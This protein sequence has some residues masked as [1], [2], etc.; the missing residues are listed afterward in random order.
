MLSSPVQ[1][2]LSGGANKS[3]GNSLVCREGV[4][5]SNHV[6]VR[7][8]RDNVPGTCVVCCVVLSKACSGGMAAN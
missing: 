7:V 6:R 8:I 4:P 2:S 1:C 5:N 3:Y